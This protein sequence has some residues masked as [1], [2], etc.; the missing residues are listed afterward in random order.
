MEELDKIIAKIQKLMKLA[1]DNPNDEEGQTALMLAQKMLLKHNLSMQD[2][3][4]KDRR[5][6]DEN[7]VET[8]SEYLVRMPWWKSEL[9]VI[10][11]KNFRCK[12]IRRRYYNRKETTMIF[13]G[14][15]DD[16][17]IATEVYEATLMYLEYRLGRI[18]KEHLGVAYRNSYLQGFLH[19]IDERFRQQKRERE[20]RKFEL[21]LQ[22]PAEVD[23]AFKEMKLGSYNTTNPKVLNEEAYLIGHEHAKKSKL[24]PKEILNRG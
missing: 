3:D 13:F 18:R 23:R 19:G 12:S 20:L 11:A 16:V 8:E 7:I 10:L 2:I 24:M 21:M 14:Y 5:Q 22:V 9:H 6:T 4:R 15:K 17:R 1:Q